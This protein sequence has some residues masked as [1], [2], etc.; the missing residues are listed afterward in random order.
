MEKYDIYAGGVFKS[1]NTPL[2]VTNPYTGEVFAQTYIAG[3]PELEE[4]IASALAVEREMKDLSVYKRYEI[5]MQISE[6]I[7]SKREYLADIL[8]REA[9]KPLIYALG[10]IDRAT[11]T[12]L[13]A[14]EESKR[15][16]SEYLSIDWAP[17]GAGREGIIRYF[18]LGL[19]AGI[20]PF[21]F[22]LNLAVHKIAPAI[23]AGNPIILKPARSTP[24][25]TL[26]LAKIIH[27]TDLP[28]GAFSVLPMDRQAGNQLVTDQRFKKLT[29]TGSPEVGWRMKEQ[30][31]KKKVTLELGGNAGA[32]VTC[33]ADMDH[34][35][36]RCLLAGF[37]YQGQVCIHLQ[38]IF[39]HRDIFN[40]F[41]GTL[42]EKAKNLRQ[43]APDDPETEITAMIDEE[44]ALRVE[45][46]VNEAVE[47][48]AEILCGGNRKFTYYEPTILTKT[49]KDMKVNAEEIFGPV[50]TVESYESFQDAVHSVD[51]SRFGLQAGVFTDSIEEMNYAFE[52]ISVGGLIINDAPI[53]RIDHMPYGGVKDSG[54][55]REGL[56][57]AI[58]EMMEPKLLIKNK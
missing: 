40:E 14:A 36:N 6:T 39:V 18:P 52:N 32:I 17:S 58:K 37:A 48:G 51:D 54:L 41:T 23:A 38:R 56:K 30:A 53:F 22:P 24:L 4:S 29:F 55:G 49:K 13:V 28:K 1:N 44:N 42:V 3:T 46:W 21:N 2:E 57:Y 27:N 47:G 16:P 45:E 43:G 8:A 11:Q 10:E 33:S 12:F 50:V 34:A 25:S 9:A 20:S 5:L 35:V 26:E 7:R 31:G 19:T 15:L